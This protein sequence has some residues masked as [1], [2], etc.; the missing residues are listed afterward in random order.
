M[1][2]TCFLSAA[3][4]TAILAAL[5]FPAASAQDP[6][7]TNYDESRVGTFELPD[8]FLCRDGTKVTTPE[9]WK[10][11]RRGELL[12]LF[13]KD[14]YGVMPTADCARLDSE[15]LH[16]KTVFG[17]KAIQRQV[18]LYLHAPEKTPKM[19]LLIYLP[20][21]AQ[22]PAAA[23][24]APNFMGNPTVSDDPDIIVPEV[25]DATRTKIG[26]PVQRGA[27]KSRWAIEKILERGY[28]L[29]TVYYE[30]IDPDY[31]DQRQ[32]GV[33]P[34][35]HA[36]E[37]KHNIPKQSRGATITAWAWGLSRALDYLQTLPEIDPAKVAVMGHSRLGKTALWAAA[38][39]ER[40]AASISNDS[41]CGGA[42]LT[43]RNFGE[44][45]ASMHD[46]IPWWFCPKYAT[47]VADPNLLPFDQHEL[48]AL[49]APRP[50]YIA[51]ASEDLWADPK[52]EFLSALGADPVYRL[53][54]TDGLAG[55]TEQPPVNTPVGGTIHY[56]V[57]SGDHDVTD[58]DWEQYLNFLD[59]YVRGK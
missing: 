25:P 50:V 1:K 2:N 10:Q 5:P 42:A 3:L 24:L 27:K 18:V 19:N 36:W 35:F 52:G 14:M 49:I 45:I 40:F 48:I 20:A 23:I 46:M 58:Y 9:E 41:G 12:A 26:E 57:R 4:L 22:G 8:P 29:I 55:V 13:Q 11:K 53:L 7:G 51:S 31:D 34:L 6:P 44:T 15:L 39:D 43:R 54:G 17:G 38:C 47:F 37:D 33:H 30:E 16:E 56:H 32:N 21:N 28:A 59:K